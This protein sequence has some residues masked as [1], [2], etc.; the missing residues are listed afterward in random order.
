MAA[1]TIKNYFVNPHNK[2]DYTR[3][4]FP[5]ERTHSTNL[6]TGAIVPVGYVKCAPG[7]TVPNKFGFILQSAPLLGPSVDNAYI[8]IVSVWCPS[9][10]VMAD[11][12]EW[13]GDN[14]TYAWTL[15]NN[16]HEPKITKVYTKYD[17]N[18]HTLSPTYYAE[19]YLGPHL[20]FR[21]WNPSNAGSTDFA[22][23]LGNVTT[24]ESIYHNGISVLLPRM[25]ELIWNRLFRNENIQ[26]PILF[27]KQSGTDLSL[28]VSNYQDG[29]GDIRFANRL[30]NMFTMA[31]KTPSIETVDLGLGGSIIAPVY[32]GV[33]DFINISNYSS[34]P[35]TKGYSIL[36]G[37]RVSGVNLGL[38][39][40]GVLGSGDTASIGDSIAFSNLYADL[41]ALTVNS[42]YYAQ[43]LQRYMYKAS[44]GRRP[45]EFYKT[46][47]GIS[48]SNAAYD[49]PELLS[50]KRFKINISRVVATGN[51]TD[52]QGNLQG[53]GT[54]GAFSLTSAGGQL[55]PQFTAT[56]YGALMIFAVIRT[57]ESFA[58]G[59]D[60][61]LADHDLLS[62]YLPVFD[63][64]GSMAVELMELANIPYAQTMRVF[65]YQEAW[66]YYRYHVNDVAG[67]FVPGEPLS[68]MT[69]ARDFPG[70]A[71]SAFSVNYNFITQLPAE[72]DRMLQ[73]PVFY[74]TPNATGVDQYGEYYN[75]DRYQWVIQFALT[76]DLVATMSKNSEPLLYG[77]RI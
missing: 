42:L 51:S 44:T 13:L 41:S 49:D 26:N 64:I 52:G 16:V 23:A 56:E 11:F 12:N 61:H 18:G 27:S 66:Y 60:R 15:G 14:D 77:N 74:G 43:M 71:L 33:T 35:A 58:S 39:T 7:T 30:K 55:F 4:V 22:S 3:S 68:Y 67:I 17:S 10:L 63:H 2:F 69:F 50:Q 57:Q 38:G 8:D 34:M 36:T 20:G 48:K 21:W 29:L 59:I 9:R 28:D 72:F 1:K 53:L 5:Y 65:G 32:P 45:V 6:L 76:G 54:Q 31:W 19:H 40:N 70:N 47:F 24:V 46:F 37:S 73:L 62:T 75:S 25:Y